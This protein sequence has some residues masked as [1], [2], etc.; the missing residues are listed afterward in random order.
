MRACQLDP[1]TE[2]LNA[3]GV[4]CRKKDTSNINN[5][6]KVEQET[7]HL[8]SWMSAC[9]RGRQAAIALR[10]LL[11]ISKCCCCTVADTRK[12]SWNWEELRWKKELSGCRGANPRGRAFLH[13]LKSLRAEHFI[14][15]GLRVSKEMV[16]RDSQLKLFCRLYQCEALPV[17]SSDWRINTYVREYL[18]L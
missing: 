15:R 10:K 18:L 9:D 5:G 6:C 3:D 1:W 13:S 4:S 12:A 7:L 16:S 17:E 8:W 11:R 2:P 14:F